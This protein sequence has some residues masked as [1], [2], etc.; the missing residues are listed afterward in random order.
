[1]VCEGAATPGLADS[2]GG[3]SL[4]ETGDNGRPRRFGLP[5]PGQSDTLKHLGNRV[6]PLAEPL[7]PS[8]FDGL[9]GLDKTIERCS[10]HGRIIPKTDT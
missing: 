7:F 4:G 9:G 8:T 10:V 1:M 2:I 6:K 5:L 3:P